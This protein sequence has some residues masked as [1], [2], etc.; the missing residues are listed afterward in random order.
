MH[1]I[2]V[3]LFGVA[4]NQIHKNVC[5]TLCFSGSDNVCGWLLNPTVVGCLLL[6]A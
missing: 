5:N 3:T 6:M 2:P 1:G 4:M